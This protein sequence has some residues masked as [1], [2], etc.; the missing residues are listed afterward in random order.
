MN[1]CKAG[2]FPCIRYLFELLSKERDK[3]KVIKEMVKKYSCIATCTELRKLVA[4]LETVKTL[5]ESTILCKV[6]GWL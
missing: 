2:E 5:E 1:S 4:A 3:Y 6:R